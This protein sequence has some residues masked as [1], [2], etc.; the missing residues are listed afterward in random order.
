MATHVQQHYVPEFLLKQWHSSPDK[1]LTQFQWMRGTLLVERFTAKAVA[2]EPHLYSQ[3]THEP[4]PNVS[5]ER[6]FLGPHIDEPA[7][8]VH[9]KILADGHE[10]LTDQERYEWSRFMLSLVVRTPEMID[11]M[12]RT[13]RMMMASAMDEQPDGMLHIRKG[14]PK[15]S[16]REWAEENRPHIFEDVGVRTLPAVLTSPKLNHAILGSKWST[17]SL[18]E[19][20]VDALIADN[21]VVYLGDIKDGFSFML[22][23]SPGT[24]FV[25][26]SHPKDTERALEMKRTG[27]TKSV[28][29]HLAKH[30]R[31]YVYATG[32]Q[33]EALIEKYLRKPD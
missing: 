5:L 21:P 22:P 26:A 3:R 15:G 28:N 7:A 8:V 17:V 4:T 25:V 2:K 12:R 29:R 23:I 20:T 16:L 18:A 13:G 30:A 27:L 9:K 33:H 6:D 10:K 31:R 14:D 1:K 11:F 19:S 32:R 24:A